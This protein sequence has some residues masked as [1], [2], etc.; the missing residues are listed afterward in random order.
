MLFRS[1]LVTDDV[2][3]GLHEQDVGRGRGCGMWG[4]V[5]KDVGV[6]FGGGEVFVDGVS[7]RRA[8]LSLPFAIVESP[9]FCVE[10]CIDVPSCSNGT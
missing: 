1:H 9:L 3:M 4:C 6:E 8:A 10:D 5:D 7:C 2:V